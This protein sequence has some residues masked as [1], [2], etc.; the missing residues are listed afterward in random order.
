VVSDLVQLPGGRKL[1][2]ES[3]R[4]TLGRGTLPALEIRGYRV[5]DGV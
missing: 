1:W 3:W 4:K 2:V 5:P